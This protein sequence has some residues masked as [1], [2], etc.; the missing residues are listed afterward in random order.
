M[1]DEITLAYVTAISDYKIK[2][3]MLEEAEYVLP[4]CIR[5]R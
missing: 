2:R 3:N 4:N 5:A 1:D